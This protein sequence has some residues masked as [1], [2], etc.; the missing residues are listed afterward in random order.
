MHS[1][2]SLC[3]WL[4]AQSLIGFLVTARDALCYVPFFPYEASG[5]F[6]RSA[7]KR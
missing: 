6:A 1:L 3:L 4:P 7:T 5:F 2:D